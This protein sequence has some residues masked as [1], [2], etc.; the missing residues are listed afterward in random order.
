MTRLA[1]A[2]VVFHSRRSQS[3]EEL[4]VARRSAVARGEEPNALVRMIVRQLRVS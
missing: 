2:Q 4:N 3:H 1:W